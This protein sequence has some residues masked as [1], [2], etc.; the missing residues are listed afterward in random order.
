MRLAEEK[1]FNTALKKE[2]IAPAARLNITFIAWRPGVLAPADD[3]IL[4]P[5]WLLYTW[6]G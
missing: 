3:G 4:D 5:C 6:C 1:D 2:D